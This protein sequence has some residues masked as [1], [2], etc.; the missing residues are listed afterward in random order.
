MDAFDDLYAANDT[1]AATFSA[2]GLT[3]TAARGL[4]VLTCIDS[5]ID[6]V[7]ARNSATLCDLGVFV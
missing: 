4:A 1:Y 6:P 7:G 2:P 5:R 3:G